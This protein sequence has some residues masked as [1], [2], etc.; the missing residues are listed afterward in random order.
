MDFEN[1]FGQLK[2]RSNTL[3][4][5]RTFATTLPMERIEAHANVRL[6][7]YDQK[8]RLE[9][10][11]YGDLVALLRIVRIKETAKI[12]ADSLFIW[13]KKA[14]FTW[15]TEFVIIRYECPMDE[16][17]RQLKPSEDCEIQE[18]TQTEVEY[19]LVCNV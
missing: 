14:I 4:D 11:S 18:Y 1:F 8:V 10:R 17:P 19:R 9:A 16:I 12:D 7:S 2:K 5:L 3:A 6:D 15:K 13:H